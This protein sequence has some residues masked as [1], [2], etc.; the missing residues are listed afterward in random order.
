M[1]NAVANDESR[2]AAE[3]ASFAEPLNPFSSR[4][5]RP[6]A[7]AYLFDAAHDARSIVD[8]FYSAGRRGAI[9][10][11]HGSGK[12]TLLSTL[13][14]EIAAR[15]GAVRTITLRDGG[16]GMP[17]LSELK[18][19]PSTVLVVDGYEQLGWWRRMRLNRTVRRA[20]AGLLVTA[21]SPMDMPT[22]Y[23]TASSPEIAARLVRGLV[24][25]HAPGMCLPIDDR[26]IA[27][28][29]TVH[30]GD[31]RELLFGLYDLYES[32]RS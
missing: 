22:L 28:R 11:P 8:A 21:H 17:R 10:G 9:I 1:D 32:Q 7:I 15:G 31:V 14:P 25:E 3:P 18:L 5:V 27:R 23:T 12:T 30:D 19:G 20:G 2:A 26:E 13:E 29:L 6:G 4:Y 16:A 24:A